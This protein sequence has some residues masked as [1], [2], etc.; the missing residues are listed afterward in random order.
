[1]TVVYEWNIYLP[2]QCLYEKSGYLM[3]TYDSKMR[4]ICITG[5]V[6][7]ISCE[8]TANI[9]FVGV[10]NNH[11]ELGQHPAINKSHRLL[12]VN[13]EK[14][15]YPRARLDPPILDD[16]S[17]S[18]A[19]NQCLVILYDSEALTQSFTLMCSTGDRAEIICRMSHSLNTSYYEMP[20]SEGTQNFART[21]YAFQRHRERHAAKFLISIIFKILLFIKS[22]FLTS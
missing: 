1:M 9:E 18:T 15:I 3:G 14:T 5:L 2:I 22:F 19:S 17:R 8:E 6:R 20:M 10:W 4:Y 11:R 16:C 12:Y 13:A 7:S 21:H